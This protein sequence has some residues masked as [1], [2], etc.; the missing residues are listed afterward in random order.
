MTTYPAKRVSS[1]NLNVVN[2]MAMDY[3]PANDNGGRMGL[4][5]V[6]A[7]S[8]THNQVVAAG[9]TATIGVTPM[10]GVNDVASEIFQLSDAQMLLNFANANSYITY[11]D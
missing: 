8:N 11:Q 5:A 4:S 3:G 6:H 9:L 7:A 1:V 2:I 10:I